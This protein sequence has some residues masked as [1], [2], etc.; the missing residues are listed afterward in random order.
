MDLPAPHQQAVLWKLE[1]ILLPQG[2][3]EDPST[4]CWSF[5]YV[6]PLLDD[7]RR[8]ARQEDR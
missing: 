5:A 7:V 3:S 1:K 2:N 4:P 6:E 8:F